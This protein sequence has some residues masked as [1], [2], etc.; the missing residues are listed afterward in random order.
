MLWESRQGCHGE[1]ERLWGSPA[2]GDVGDKAVGRRTRR[3]WAQGLVPPRLD[4]APSPAGPELPRLSGSALGGETT[5]GGFE[6]G[7]LL[8]VLAGWGRAAEMYI[9]VPVVPSCPGGGLVEE[10]A[11]WSRRCWGD[12]AV[13][14]LDGREVRRSPRTTVTISGCL[15]QVQRETVT[16]TETPIPLG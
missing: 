4:I 3:C 1:A 14:R 16:Q 2:A 10:A 15:V 5:R 13:L 12:A 6:P 9:P 11:Q 7:K 8:V